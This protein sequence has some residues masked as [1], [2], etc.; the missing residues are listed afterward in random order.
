MRQREVWAWLLLPCLVMT[1]CSR[2]TFVKPK[3][4]RKDGEQIAQDYHVADSPEVQKR[5]KTQQR[6]GLAAQRLRAGDYAM[7]EREAKEVLKVDP[8]SVD[9]LTILGIASD[10]QD[11][12]AKA[13]EYYKRAADLA[14]AKGSVL[15]NYGAW[16]CQN[17][18]PA[19]SLA[20]FDRALKDPGY[21]SPASALANAGDCAQQA[22]QY[23]RSE[24]DLR[25]ALALEPT[26]AVALEA[27]A[28]NAYRE[29]QY[30]DARAF[31]ERR[32]DAAPANASVLKLAAGIEQQLGDTRA[33]QRY[34][35]TLRAEFPNDASDISRGNARQ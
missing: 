5:M 8:G 20:W 7:A 9:A 18:D 6:L 15:N 22:G 28:R 16:L 30:M 11:D 25:Q 4:D 23:P 24:R 21:A 31:V 34:Q 1:G 14:P 35:Q 3:M 26:N 29:Q 10:Q 13:G 19:E 12:V 17:R 32:L 27:L 33:A 2:L